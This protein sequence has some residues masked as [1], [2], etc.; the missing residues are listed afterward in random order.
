MSF[1]TIKWLLN[2]TESAQQNKQA[3]IH[4]SR[5]ALKDRCQKNGLPDWAAHPPKISAV[6]SRSLDK[7]KIFSVEPSDL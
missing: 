3:N 7:G 2:A 6:T 1:L 4:T 5:V